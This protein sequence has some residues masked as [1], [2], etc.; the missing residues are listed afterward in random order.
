MATIA[1]Y[2]YKCTGETKIYI[3]LKI[4]KLKDIRQSTR[5]T[6]KDAR[7][8]RKE[9]QLPNASTP[10]NK[11]LR[12][13]LSG[14]RLLIE[15]KIDNIEK[16]DA[17]SLR[18]IDGKWL[19]SIVLTYVNEAPPTK[20]DLLVNY[21]QHFTNSL[22]RRTY[23][24]KGIRYKYNQKT[25]DKYQNITR[26]FTEYQK[27]LGKAIEIS[28]ID[29]QW[30][31]SFLEYLTEVKGLAVNTK[32]KFITRL[33]TILKD[34]EQND[35]KVNPKYK[36][37]MS[38]EAENIVTFLTFEEIDKIIEKKM[39]TDRLQIAK[40][41]FIISCYTSQ[42]ISDLFRFRKSNIC[43][44]EGGKYLVF[45]Q[46]KTKLS[47][48]VPIHYHVENV[49]KRYNGTFPPNFSDNEQSNR[50][51]LSKLI[52]DVCRISGIREKVR[53]RYNGVIGI[54]PKWK[55]ISNHTGRRSFASNFYNLSD[56][57]N[58]M[59]MNITGHANEKSFYKYIDKEDNTLSRK[60]RAMFDQME[61]DDAHSKESQLSIVKEAT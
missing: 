6:I 37:I 9:K 5:L 30:A 8:W 38:F 11:D 29:E 61:I 45:K 27:Y 25:I 48:E 46:Y 44:I 39:P 47:I 1:F 21:A 18:D 28:G 15:D 12:K 53:G 51:I 42:R 19:K 41:W 54:Y 2:P 60:G 3:R 10:G 40:D 20:L 13:K 49:L 17:Q 26:Q 35:I 14:L 55:L 59:I 4:G 22:T 16:S 57:S 23:K 34:A 7:T 50:S 32:G 43:I 56:W 58:A 36:S 24:R 31:N 52:K 33:K